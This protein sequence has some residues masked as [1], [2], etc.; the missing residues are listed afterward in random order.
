MGRSTNVCQNFLESR[1]AIKMLGN[2][3]TDKNKVINNIAVKFRIKSVLPITVSGGL[4]LNTHK[5]IG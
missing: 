2:K 3:N 4:F 5:F 1:T